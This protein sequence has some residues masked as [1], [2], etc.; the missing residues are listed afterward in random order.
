VTSDEQKSSCQVIHSEKILRFVRIF[1]PAGRIPSPGRGVIGNRTP[2][3]N[4]SHSREGGN[5]VRP[6]R[7]SHGWRSGFPPSREWLYSGAP[8]SRQ[9]HH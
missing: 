5:P 9:W 4:I 1:F 2:F 7:I 6:R 3:R 8:V